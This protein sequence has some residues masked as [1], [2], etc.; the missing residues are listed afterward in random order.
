MEN[1]TFNIVS[2]SGN[3][4]CG[5]DTLGKNMVKLLK[6]QG[7]NSKTISFANQLKESVDEFLVSKLGISAF[8]EDD[9]EKKIIRPFLV[10]WGTEIMRSIDKQHWIKQLEKQL[11]HDCI[12]IVTDARFVNELDWVKKNNGL[13][14][15]L[16]RDG[17]EPANEYESKEN[18]KI[19]KSVDL[20]FHIGNFDDSKLLYLTSSEILN[21]LINEKTYKSW[22]AT[23]L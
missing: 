23:C 19:K 1:K 13:S 11:S 15:F 16:S 22:K 2:I 8:T 9:E 5:K 4:R 18:E 20:T 12:Y 6:E 3:A 21:K 10:C 14:V 7:F 17:I